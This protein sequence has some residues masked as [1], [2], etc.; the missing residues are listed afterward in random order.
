MWPF[1]KR[2]AATPKTSKAIA[3]LKASVPESDAAP[4]IELSRA[5]SPVMK[6]LNNDL[7]IAYVVDTGDSFSY[8]Q[9]RD[10]ETD[11]VTEA[12]LHEIGLRN[13]A[14]L[15]DAGNL[16]V[17]PH[18]NIFAV[19]LD[20]NFEASMILLDQLWTESLREYVHGDFLVAIP[21]RDILAFCDASSTAGR[22]E[23]MQLVD[24]LKASQ[25]HLL[26]QQLYVRRGSNWVPEDLA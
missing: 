4:T 22:A 5:D 11:S 23:L 14:T 25:D 19:L 2:A 3:Y 1:R 9:Y 16:R 15:A 13:L 8:V 24:R 10:L 21:T 12:E 18:G 20:G 7:F 6:I 17:V 26:T